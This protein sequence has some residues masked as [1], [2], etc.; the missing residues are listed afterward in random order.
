MNDTEQ[1]ASAWSAMLQ[2]AGKHPTPPAHTK[3]RTFAGYKNEADMERRG[4][5]REPFARSNS[6]LF[7]NY[8]I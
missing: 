3:A 1:R 7:N 5:A 8:R 2:Q 4:G 6:H